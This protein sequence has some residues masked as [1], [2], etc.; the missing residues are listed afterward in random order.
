MD[1]KGKTAILGSR[2]PLGEMF[3]YSSEL[4][5]ITS[6]RAEFSMHFYRYESVPYSIAEEIVN[7]RRKAKTGA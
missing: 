5:N 1:A 7:E 4:R 2:V 3:G 6:G